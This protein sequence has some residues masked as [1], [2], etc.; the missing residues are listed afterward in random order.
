MVSLLG[1]KLYAVGGWTAAGLP[2]P[3]TEVYDP[4]TNHWSTAAPNPHPYAASGSAVLNG[5]LYIVG[6]CALIGSC[7]RTDVEIYDPAT[8]TWTAGQPFPESISSTACGTIAGSIYCAGGDAGSAMT[9]RTYRYDPITDRWSRRADLPMPVSASA[10]TTSGQR[11]LLSGGVIHEGERPYVA[12]NAGFSYDPTANAWT[13]LP[14]SNQATYRSTGACGFFQIGGNT[15]DYSS[16]PL[17][18]VQVLP[19]H[20]DCTDA[21][22]VP[23]L[24]TS[25]TTLTV[26]AH[27]SVHITVTLHTSGASTTPPGTDRAQ[28]VFITDTPYLVPAVNVTMT[29]T[30]RRTPA[31]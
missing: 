28:L 18:G 21:A 26:P 7:H 1:Q 22:E 24:S 8:D 23:W 31:S 11:L 5:K 25:A 9:A 27:G 10:A 30:P 14:A 12:T 29:V 17:A 19:G 2:D 4:A 3:T 6:G 15:A 16:V 13:S 20:T